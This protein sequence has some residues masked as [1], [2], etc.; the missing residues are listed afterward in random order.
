M[1]NKE[2]IIVV[3]NLS[4]SFKLENKNKS[5]LESFLFLLRGKDKRI[6][7][8]LDNISFSVEEGR[9]LGVVGRNGCGKSTLLRLIAEIYYP[10]KGEIKTEGDITYLSTLSNGLKPK[11][12]MRENIYLSGVILGLRK[13]DIKEKF[14][15]I[16]EFSGLREFVDTKVFQFSSGMITRL[17]FSITIHCITH[18][19]IDILLLDEIFAGGGDREFQRKA[20]EK[21]EELIKSGTTVVFA[22]HKLDLINKYCD[23]AIWIDKEKIVKQGKPEKVCN[24]YIKSVKE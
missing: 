23:K 22:S 4:K 2:K 1:E 5:A 17:N 11:L 15:E 7:Q 6:L 21:M 10:N 24:A 12:T 14:D 19:K 3:K 20:I 8:V 18:K 9:N 13:R 16:V